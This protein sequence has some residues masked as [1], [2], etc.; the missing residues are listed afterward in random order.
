MAYGRRRGRAIA[1][2]TRHGQGKRSAYRKRRPNTAS[3]IRYGKPT[4]RKQKYQI[5][6][7][8][9][10][11]SKLWKIEKSKRLFT[12]WSSYGSNV[13]S[14]WYIQPMVE[15]SN[16]TNILRFSTPVSESA[17]TWV[18]NANIQMIAGLG[19]SI[20]DPC[21]VHV[22]L[23]RPAR[24]NQAED[25]YTTP[26]VAGTDY[27]VCPEAES[28]IIRLNPGKYKTLL[29]KRI[30]FT[31]RTFQ[32]TD[33]HDNTLVKWSW[34]INLN[35][36]IKGYSGIWKDKAMVELP[37]DKQIY[38]MAYCES[39]NASVYPFFTWDSLVT[40]VNSGAP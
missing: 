16:W 39:A 21:W 19:T 36:P 18:R 25:P 7:N 8:H 2:R 6:R 1:R 13:A 23:V 32:N 33:T 10:A 27:Y 30:Q 22:W 24:W 29:Y 20:E 38:L 3:K 9:N 12:D 14:G 34:N 11:V 31:P 17:S 35:F 37:V 5:L 40:C 4:A 28:G 15:P 26:P